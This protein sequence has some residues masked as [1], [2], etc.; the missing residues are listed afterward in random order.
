MKHGYGEINLKIHHLIDQMELASSM[1][2]LAKQWQSSAKTRAGHSN[3][4]FQA[5]SPHEYCE[6]PVDK[7]NKFCGGVGWCR[8]EDS[9]A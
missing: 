1:F 9:K 8:Y 7:L 3:E 6:V 5:T 4:E 2:H